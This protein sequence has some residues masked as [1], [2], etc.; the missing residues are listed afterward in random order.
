MVELHIYENIHVHQGFAHPRQVLLA[1]GYEC[2]HFLVLITLRFKPTSLSL[3]P[4][5]K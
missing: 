5:K 2:I 3:E 1:L 4:S